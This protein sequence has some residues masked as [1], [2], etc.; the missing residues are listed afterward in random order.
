MYAVEDAM[1]A[2]KIEVRC[3]ACGF[4]VREN[5]YTQDHID[6]GLRRCLNVIAGAGGLAVFCKHLGLDVTVVGPGQW[7]PFDLP[8][9]A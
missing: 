5:A 4:C 1:E 6:G 2:T 9:G 3:P 7:T 8:N